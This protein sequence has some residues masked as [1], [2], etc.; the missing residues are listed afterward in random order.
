M[1][2][3]ERERTS[4]PLIPV[5]PRSTDGNLLD[6]FKKL[7][8][9]KGKINWFSQDLARWTAKSYSK[10]VHVMDKASVKKIRVKLVEQTDGY[11]L[12]CGRSSVN[13]SREQYKKL[14]SLYSAQNAHF[15]DRLFLTLMRYKPLQV[16][17]R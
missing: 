5:A 1:K 9:D 7:G 13:I 15:H 10:F 4:E 3:L 11:V 14:R 8:V 6:E 12:Q 17:M 2:Y 16:R